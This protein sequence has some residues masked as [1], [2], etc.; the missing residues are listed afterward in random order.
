MKADVAHLA[1]LVPVTVDLVHIG[2]DATPLA[3]PVRHVGALAGEDLPGAGR[4]QD[5]HAE[6]DALAHMGQIDSSKMPETAVDGWSRRPLPTA[7]ERR[8]ERCNK[9]GV[10]IAPA[11][12]TTA[13]LRTISVKAG[14]S[15]CRTVART[16]TARPSSI[17]TRSTVQLTMI[18]ARRR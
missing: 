5:A 13:R 18:R 12:A 4:L 17:S 6:L 3:G 15:G 7:F 9:A 16:P 14:I 11:D 2:V 8:P 1:R 10:A